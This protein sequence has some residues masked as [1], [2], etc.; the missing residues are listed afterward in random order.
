MLFSFIIIFI[1]T[2]MCNTKGLFKSK[3]VK[4]T[5]LIISILSVNSAFQLNSLFSS[6]YIKDRY[7]KTYQNYYVLWGWGC[8][9]TTYQNTVFFTA[10]WYQIKW[11]TLSSLLFLTPFLPVLTAAIKYL[12]LS[13]GC[14][15]ECKMRCKMCHT[16]CCMKCCGKL[17]VKKP[18]K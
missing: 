6:P 16:G 14:C 15:Y 12:V 9:Q 17:F 2:H 5:V 13:C 11:T 3:L 10:L 18:A 4:N 1:L 8:K 7:D